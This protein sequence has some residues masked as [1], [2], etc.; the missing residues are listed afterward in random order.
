[1][2]DTLLSLW[3]IE[4]FLIVYFRAFVPDLFQI[5]IYCFLH[6][7]SSSISSM[8]RNIDSVTPEATRMKGVNFFFIFVLQLSALTKLCAR[9]KDYCP[10]PP[11]AITGPPGM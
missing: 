7:D 5:W 4:D 11:A 10:E 9:T 6:T 1:M 2:D 8:N 3:N